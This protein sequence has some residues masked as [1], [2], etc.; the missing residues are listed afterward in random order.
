MTVVFLMTSNESSRF[1]YLTWTLFSLSFPLHSPVPVDRGR[2]ERGSTDQG[3][4]RMGTVPTETQAHH[5]SGRL[6]PQFRGASHHRL[7]QAQVAGTGMEAEAGM[8]HGESCACFVRTWKGRI[9]LF[10]LRWFVSAQF[11]LLLNTIS[12]HVDS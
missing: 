11:F 4:A 10:K 8:L 2:G 6:R 12:S 3:T 9:H 5:R 1:D 7:C